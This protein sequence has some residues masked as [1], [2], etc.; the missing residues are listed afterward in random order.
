MIFPYKKDTKQQFVTVK[1]NTVVFMKKFFEAQI[2]L[3]K[4]DVFM[5]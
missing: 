5:Q 2:I 3:G 1:H 4:A